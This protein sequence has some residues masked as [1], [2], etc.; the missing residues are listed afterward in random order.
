MVNAT[1][2][3]HYPQERPGTHCIGG[4]MGLGACLD[5]CRKFASPPTRIRFWTVQPIVSRY[6]NCA[7][8][9]PILTV[10]KL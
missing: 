2:R 3:L 5:R 4:W 8:R 1:L 9:A 10:G 7:V 6:T